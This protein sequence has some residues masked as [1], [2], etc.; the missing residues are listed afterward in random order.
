MTDATAPRR[1]DEAVASVPARYTSLTL[2]DGDLVIYDRQDE[3]RWVQS[4]DAVSLTEV[5]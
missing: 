1:T 3:Q 5:R 4:D 2:P